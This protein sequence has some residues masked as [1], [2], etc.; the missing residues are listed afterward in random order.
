MDTNMLQ[1][2]SNP[3]QNT[4]ESL[5]RNRSH[6]ATKNSYKAFPLAQETVSKRS[7]SG[8]SPTSNKIHARITKYCGNVIKT[9]MDQ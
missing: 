5:Q 3:Y 2:C 7:K 8:K 1:I 6:F 9:D 4:S